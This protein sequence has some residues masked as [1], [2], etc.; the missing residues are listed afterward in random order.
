[1]KGAHFEGAYMSGAD[2]RGAEV[3][4]EDLEKAYLVNTI[5][6]DGTLHK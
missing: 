1:M 5:L 2:L 3:I 6:P 4:L